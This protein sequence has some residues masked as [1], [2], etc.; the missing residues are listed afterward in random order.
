MALTN[1]QMCLI[2]SI[3]EGNLKAA[4]QWAIICCDE[5]TTQKNASFVEQYKSILK[6][7]KSKFIE[8]P[9]NVREFIC[10]EDVSE[11]FNINRYF[12]SERE[13][14]LVEQITR[15]SKAAAKLKEM[16]IPYR[17][18][19]LL[20]G[21]SGTG[22][23]LF[24]RYIAY[25]FELPFLYLKFSSLISSYMGNTSKNIAEAFEFAMKIP[26]VFMLD[27]LDT[28][29]T[30]RT[31]GTKG[32]DSEMNRV[33]VTIMQELDR[34]RNDAVVL[35]ATNRID[36]IDSAVL[37][38]FSVKHEVKPFSDDEKLQLL[39]SFLSDVGVDFSGSRIN[40]ILSSANQSAIINRAIEEI[41][42]DIIN[43]LKD[44]EQ[45]DG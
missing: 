18:S 11:T 29:S 19:T 14:S 10:A 24:G 4:K 5:D 41:A 39:G 26:C 21:E 27:E 2:R 35:A 3:A 7:Q 28:I 13:R 33:T 8:L 17:N 45:G 6:Q 42:A 15:M 9:G 23:T 44:G 40:S 30:N 32:P 1:S 38:R 12:L 36:V 20:Y 37:R 22:K 43:E 34:L 16:K 25:K 31:D